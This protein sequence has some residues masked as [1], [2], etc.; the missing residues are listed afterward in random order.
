M[1][2]SYAVQIDDI[3]AA[4]QRYLSDDILSPER[5]ATRDRDEY[6]DQGSA[7]ELSFDE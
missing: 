1:A 5:L 3:L 4:G 6:D 7:P 2:T